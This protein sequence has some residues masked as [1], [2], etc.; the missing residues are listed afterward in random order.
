MLMMQAYLQRSHLQTVSLHG[1]DPI[2]LRH[3]CLTILANSRAVLV[4]AQK[5]KKSKK[6]YLKR[7]LFQ[8]VIELRRLQPLRTTG[9]DAY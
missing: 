2:I 7:D 4:G 5:K 6:I 8:E 1:G 3:I 9:S